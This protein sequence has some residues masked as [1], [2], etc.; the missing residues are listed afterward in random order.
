[1]HSQHNI[2]IQAIKKA[3]KIKLTFFTEEDLV[4]SVTLCIP[5]D[6]NPGRRIKDKSCLYHFLC[7]EDDGTGYVLS[8]SPNQI[9]NMEPTEESFDIRNLLTDDINL[10]LIQHKGLFGRI[11][12]FLKWRFGFGSGSN[13]SGRV[14]RR[15]N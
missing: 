7:F 3:R 15:G 12:M 13:R 6:Y 5:L 11:V 10:F 8:L 4:K 9:I 2:F 14:D 1:M